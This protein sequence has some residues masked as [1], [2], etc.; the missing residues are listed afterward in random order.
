MLNNVTKVSREHQDD[1]AD[2]KYTSTT[3]GSR[4]GQSWSRDG[5][6]KFN[7]LTKM[8]QARRRAKENCEA[9]EENL[10]NWCRVQGGLSALNGGANRSSNDDDAASGE[11]DEE[12]VEAVGEHALYEV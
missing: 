3:E 8:V 5:V 6:T 7:E 11:E 2:A 9:M 10:R 12:E 4:R 1:W